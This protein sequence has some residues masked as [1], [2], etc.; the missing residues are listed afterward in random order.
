MTEGY[1][2]TGVSIGFGMITSKIQN[3]TDSFRIARHLLDM[4]IIRGVNQVLYAD[5]EKEECERKKY[6]LPNDLL[7]SLSE[8]VERNALEDIKKEIFFIFQN[9]LDFCKKEDISVYKIFRGVI[10]NILS[11]IKQKGDFP[12]EFMDIYQELS[13]ELNKCSRYYDLMN[14]LPE[15]IMEEILKFQTDDQSEGSL[16]M[17][18]VLGYVSENYD[19]PLKLEDVAEQVYISPAYLGIIFKKETGKNFT[20]YLT[21]LRMKK[22]KE[23][24]LDVRIN[25]NEVTYKVG[26]NNVRYFSRIFKENV[27]ISPKEYRKIH[28]NRIY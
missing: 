12:D 22:A 14:T 21:D 15:R 5:N 11:V 26:Y 3:L 9:A 16:I 19:K 6:V 25:I 28:A 2:N 17:K 24:L 10:L 1:T 18:R 7:G 8:K 23:L 20:T 4:R 13:L 27:G